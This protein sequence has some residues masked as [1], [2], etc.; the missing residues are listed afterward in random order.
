MTA[1][2]AARGLVA[3]T[4]WVANVIGNAAYKF[5]WDDGLSRAAALAYTSLF[6]LVP[7]SALTV[8]IMSTF[9][10][11]EKGYSDVLETIMGQFFP[12][13]TNPQLDDLKIQIRDTLSS[14]SGSIR[15][16]NIVSVA[17][18]VVTSIALLNTIES[19]LNVVWRATSEVSIVSKIASFWTVITLGP[20]LILV[21]IYYSTIVTGLAQTDP[22]FSSALRY[23]VNFIIPVLISWAALTI[24]FY[25]LPSARVLLHEA[26]FG[27]LIAA[28]LFEFVK[29][30]FAYYIGLST[31]YGTL[32]GVLAAIPLFLFWL[33]VTWVVILFGAQIAYHAGMIGILRGRSKYA[34]DLGEI[35]AILGLRIL[36]TIGRRFNAGEQPPTEA[37]ITIEMG[38]DPVLI[39]TCL[40]VLAES[41]L[42]TVSDPETHARSLLVPP[43]RLKLGDVFSTFFSHRERL[44]LA[45]NDAD[46]PLRQVAFFQILRDTS[47]KAEGSEVV[48]WTLQQLLD[49]RV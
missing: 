21:S 44:H 34:T 47:A 39:R 26:G 46:N 38:S 4:M 20:L 12:S 27:A 5:Y 40:N 7:I 45:Q 31:P 14:L 6:A 43:N 29:R 37:E 24:L 16:L 42:I 48:D 33:Y 13:G 11:G 41:G 1:Q 9:G 28:V 19:A 17:A 22:L 32:Y 36:Y 35:G 23:A 3:A 18:L 15:A 10:V 30:G 25:K 8:S 2:K 49:A